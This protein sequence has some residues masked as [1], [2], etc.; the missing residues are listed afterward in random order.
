MAHID[1][2]PVI[3]R[4][5]AAKVP[6]DILGR[7]TAGELKAR[8]AH[9]HQHIST[10]DKQSDP[11]LFRVMHQQARKVL[12]AMP[13]VELVQEC[14]RLHDLAEQSSPQIQADED[15]HPYSIRGSV[16]ANRRQLIEDH[17]MPPGLTGAIESVLIGKGTGYA[18]M[19][20]LALACIRAHRK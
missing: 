15:G 5:H 1:S 6:A 18:H 19:D 16:L 11:Q 7:L 12:C 4:E 10:A 2:V 20:E 3:H 8:C 14:K 17:P 9:A 13:A